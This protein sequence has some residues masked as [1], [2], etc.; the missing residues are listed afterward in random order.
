MS[1]PSLS[2]ARISRRTFTI[3]LKPLRILSLSTHACSPHVF[4]SVSLSCLLFPILLCRPPGTTRAF[5]LRPWVFSLPPLTTAHFSS[6]PPPRRVT[7]SVVRVT[8][9]FSRPLIRF[10]ALTPPEQFAPN[11]FLIG[12]RQ[13]PRQMR[14]FSA[15]H[16]YPMNVKMF[17]IPKFLSSL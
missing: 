13:G 17:H 10:F 9:G 14:N 8:R 4:L 15:Q 5:R 1:V 6:S 16:T 7:A 2:T 11:T 12:K 3:A